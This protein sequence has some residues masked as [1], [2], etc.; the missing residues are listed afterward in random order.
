MHALLMVGKAKKEQVS[1]SPAV[2]VVGLAHEFG[3]NRHDLG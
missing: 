2:E 3:L 1:V